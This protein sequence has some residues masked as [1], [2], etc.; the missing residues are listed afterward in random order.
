MPLEF[1]GIHEDIR[2][3]IL[4]ATYPEVDA[5]GAR[6]S[7]KTW[8]AAATVI[9][10]CQKWPGIEWL[11]CR[12]SNEETRTKV[13][14]EIER[15]ARDYYPDFRPE[16]N[17]EESRFEFPE[18]A[19]QQ[20]KIYCYGLK[21]QTLAAALAKV[22]G[23]G[24]AS[25]LI[26]QAEELPQEIAD[27]LP[28]GTRQPGYPH[29]VVY[30]P[31]PPDEDHYLADRFPEENPFPHRKYFRLSVY[32]NAHNLA[33]GKLA[34]LEANFPP[35]H[36]KY[37]SLILGMR[38]PNVT[39]VP[40][41]QHAFDRALHVVP[42][43]YDENALLLEALHCGQHHPVW[44]AAQRTYHGGLAVLGGVMGKRMML[45]EFLPMMQHY[46]EEWFDVSSRSRESLRF[47]MDPPPAA[48]SSL[49]RF[50]NLNTVQ[51]EGLRPRYRENGNAADVREAVI[52]SLAAQMR[53]RAGAGQAFAV[54]NDPSR[55]LMVSHAVQKQAKF[56][57]DGLEA[58]YVW[59]Q[60][61]VSVANK[62]VRQPKEHE[63]IEGGMRCLENIALNFGAYHLSEA[64][65]DAERVKLRQQRADTISPIVGGDWQGM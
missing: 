56:F 4:N 46:R 22:R 47:C 38:G 37:K 2:A 5:E 43:T 48:Q 62:R 18:R 24:V 45:D 52:E 3:V 64:D 61:M 36:A 42:V 1:R 15:I 63:W 54:N 17:N 41:Y 44:L 13:K 53:R 40:V 27:E 55:W 7:G 21:T 50:T 57:T 34:E 10:D 25:I 11:V 33:P 19:G 31:N 16:W 28:F 26:D 14:T 9:E 20:S 35:H 65:L 49:P 60:H 29:R 51:R 32:D 30:T 59:D 23:L 58:S 39:G 6:Y 8:M 12:Y